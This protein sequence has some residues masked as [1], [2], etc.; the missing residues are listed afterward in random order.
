MNILSLIVFLPII[1]AIF[2]FF[3]RKNVALVKIVYIL[4][5]LAVLYLCVILYIDFDPNDSMQFIVMH[6][7][8]VEYGINYHL[9][10]DGVSLG[11]VMMNA[12]IMPLIAI[13]LYKRR[14]NSGY[15]I[16]LLFVQGGVM[17]AVLS[18]D[19][20]LFYLFWE[21]MLLPIFFML[22]LFGYARSNYIAM[23]FNLY[24]IFGSLLM[25]IAILYIAVIHKE[26]FGFYSFDLNNLKNIKLSSLESILAFSG[27][28]LAF[29]IK[30]PIFPFHTW[31][32]DTYRSAPTGIVIVMSAL[33]AKLGVY[34]IWRFL[35]TLFNETSHMLAPYFIGIGLFGLI[36]F[37]IS[38]MNQSH[39]KRMFAFSSASHLSL[40]V[41][42]FFIYDIYGLIGSSYLIVAHALSSAAL[43]LMVGIMFERTGTYSINELGGI[44]L[45]APRFA[46]FFAFFALSIV[47]IPSTAGFVAELLIIVGAFKYNIYVGFISAITILIAM[48]FMFKMISKVLY[49]QLSPHT[50]EFT[51]LR[52]HELL[53]LIPLAL[54]ILAM[55]IF[56]NYFIKKIKPTASFCSVEG[57]CYVK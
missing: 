26:E 1:S 14:D 27:F 52:L 15:W 9:G 13:G 22:G 34:S 50:K 47:G 38:A 42:G 5:T 55:G 19:L 51:D 35:F 46:L 6:Q 48:L 57:Q 7:W 32:S 54:L 36:Y 29:G 28:M 37:G 12:I 49:G 41:V 8:I 23:K 39:L 17:G 18:L 45:V 10:V 56:P 3:I 31:L 44:A 21:L 40:I 25:L 16:N 20:M 11:I 4:V 43:F 2:L 53:A 30:I 33:M 24:T